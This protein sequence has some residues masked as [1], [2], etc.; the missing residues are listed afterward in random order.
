MSVSTI[1]ALLQIA[2]PARATEPSSPSVV[3][4]RGFGPALE[5]AYQSERP[6]ESASPIEPSA[7]EASLEPEAT[8]GDAS[9][10]HE[11]PDDRTDDADGPVASSPSAEEQPEAEEEPEADEVEISAAASNLADEAP[12]ASAEVAPNAESSKA[13]AIVDEGAL[14]ETVNAVANSH[15]AE[16]S[17]GDGDLPDGSAK[18]ADELRRH[19]RGDAARADHDGETTAEKLSAA[20]S[21]AANKAKRLTTEAV[22]ADDS[23]SAEG[24]SAEQAEAVEA[25]GAETQVGKVG[26]EDNRAVDS[27]TKSDA[28]SAARGTKEENAERAKL[29]PVRIAAELAAAVER[30]VAQLERSGEGAT[31]PSETVATQAVES[32]SPTTA[33]P[34]AAATLDRLAAGSLR[35]ADRAES[36]ETGPSIDRPR[37]VQRVEGALRAAQQRDG[38]VQVRLAPPELGLVQIELAVQ[39]GVMTA[40]LEAETPAARNALLDNLPALRER[41]AEQNIRIEKFDVDVRRD[42]QGSGSGAPHDGNADPNESDSQERRGRS[43]APPVK[44]APSKSARPLNLTSN[45]GLDVRI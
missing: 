6:R 38:R 39:N 5:Q 13:N 45:A 40:K 4:G 17:S 24:N 32:A 10:S 1:D 26:K 19:R 34:R 37:F 42:S 15:A 27:E 18:P 16:A 11:T 12:P 44:T 35:R 14:A 28:E 25:Q 30:H 20:D 31:S 3:P 8:I 9:T 36:T 41:L 21:T 29:P 43:T 7:S 2:T 33:A 22:A 23:R